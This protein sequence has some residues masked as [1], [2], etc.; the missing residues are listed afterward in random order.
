VAL[1]R[2]RELAEDPVI[3]SQRSCPQQQYS[4]TSSDKAERRPRYSSRTLAFNNTALKRDEVAPLARVIRKSVSSELRCPSYRSS[5]TPIANL[6]SRTSQRRTRSVRCNQPNTTNPRRNQVQP[7]P[8]FTMRIDLI[9][10]QFSSEPSVDLFPF[11]RNKLHGARFELVR[12]L[13]FTRILLSTLTQTH[14][15]HCSMPIWATGY[16]RHMHGD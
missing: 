9:P 13:Q 16:R 6:K 2:S 4:C 11:A 8:H 12:E 3:S 1:D 14:A 15:S 7:H 10:G 5:I